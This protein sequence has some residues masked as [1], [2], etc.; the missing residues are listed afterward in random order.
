MEIIVID[1]NGNGSHEQN[2]TFKELERYINTDK[3]IYIPHLKN[4]NGA[5]A[6]NTGLRRASGK[7]VALLDDDDYYLPDK[8]KKQV[9]FMESRDESW[10]ACYT[11]YKRKLKSGDREYTKS[12]RGS[13]VKEILLNKVDMCSGSTLLFRKS[14]I[15]ICGYFDES[16]KRHQDYQFVLAIASRF[17]IGFIPSVESVIVETEKK[18]FI[19]TGEEMERTKKA[20][21]ASVADIIDNL[22]RE[23]QR[24]VIAHLYAD[25]GKFYLAERDFRNV[26]R[27]MRESGYPLYFLLG[28]IRMIFLH[29]YKRI[30]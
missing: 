28:V 17:K 5:A 12:K 4:I 18:Y 14:I 24:T 23:T 9:A 8:I 7:Y 22:P 20:F 19:R 3:I 27:L 2:N 11:G 21:T 13:L 29:L 10:G 30:T 26:I 1:D 25:A 15:D 16:L 6:R